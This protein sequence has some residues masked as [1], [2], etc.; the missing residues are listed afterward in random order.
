L[1]RGDEHLAGPI[2]LLKKAKRKKEEKKEK[3]KPITCLLE[4]RRRTP[5]GPIALL[6]KAKRKIEEKKRGK[7][8]NN[9]FIRVEEANTCRPYRT[10]AVRACCI[11]TLLRL[12]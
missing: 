6:K 2:A 5:A 10:S 3:K 12:F 9:L 11:K 7:N 8:T 1:S 4:S